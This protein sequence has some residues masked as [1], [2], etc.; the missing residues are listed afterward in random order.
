MAM[1]SRAA[2]KRHMLDMQECKR[3]L[4]LLN[5]FQLPI[6]STCGAAD[7]YDCALSDKKRSGST[8]NLIVPRKIGDCE[9][10]SIA[11]DELKPFIEE[12]L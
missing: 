8:V 6:H 12:G 1:V 3:I 5:Q 7:I 4:A 11:T 9:I 2:A 10:L